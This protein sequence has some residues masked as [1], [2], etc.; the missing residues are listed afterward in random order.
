MIRNFHKHNDSL[1]QYDYSY[2]E[3]K[4]VE[5]EELSPLTTYEVGYIQGLQYALSL[6]TT[7]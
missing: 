2:K 7:K 6:I 3:A 5:L 1:N 4:L